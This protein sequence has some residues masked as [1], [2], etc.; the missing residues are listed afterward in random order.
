[1]PEYASDLALLEAIVRSATDYAIITVDPDNKIMSWNP[2]AEVLLGWKAVEII[3]Q[4]G[5]T[6]F[7]PEDRGGGSE[8]ELQQAIA[9]A[10][11]G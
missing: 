7:T 4:S 9:G 11:P 1:M 10:G 2:G 3:G 8:G 6:I 5:A